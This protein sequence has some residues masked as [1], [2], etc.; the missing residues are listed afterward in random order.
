[1]DKAKVCVIAKEVTDPNGHRLILLVTDCVAEAWYGNHLQTVLDSWGKINPT[2][3]VQLFPERLWQQTA[4]GEGHEVDVFALRSGVPNYKLKQLPSIYNPKG[5]PIPITTLEKSFLTLWAKLLTAAGGNFAP[6]VIFRKEDVKEHASSTQT[7]EE[8]TAEESKRLTAEDHIAIFQ[9]VASPTA[10]HL[11]CLLAAAPLQMP[12]MQL[13]QHTMLPHSQQ[14]HLAEVFLSGLLKSLPSEKTNDNRDDVY[15]DFLPNV[16]QILLKNDSA[17]E[18][19]QVQRK[20]SDHISQHYGQ[21]IDFEAILADPENINQLKLTPDNEFFAFVTVEVL[22]RL[23]GQYAQF[24]NQL[25]KPVIRLHKPATQFNKPVILLLQGNANNALGIPQEIEGIKNLFEPSEDMEVVILIPNSVEG[26]FKKLRQYRERIVIFHFAGIGSNKE[27]SIGEKQ[28]ITV[29]EIADFFRQ[30]HNIQLFFIN[31]GSKADI[32][33]KILSKI[34]I[35]NI[36]SGV[37]SATD[38]AAKDFAINFYKRF[39]KKELQTSVQLAYEE[40]KANHIMSN[41]IKLKTIR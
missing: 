21:T 8:L 39:T 33:M 35:R 20:V 22:K 6:A 17:Q 19:I 7:S 11:A 1:M 16:R 15:Y 25:D 18:V 14:A 12:I 30:G 38:N 29:K 5:I 13:V 34:G 3:I 41:S 28:L 24:V 4:L 2:A 40:A 23:G 37:A 31:S 26:L 9:S 27:W 32:A 10:F 36:I